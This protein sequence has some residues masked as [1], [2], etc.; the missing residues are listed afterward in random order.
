VPP[1][2]PQL[3]ELAAIGTAV[4]W[5]VTALAFAAAGRRIGSLNVNLIRLAI[6]AVLLA[7]ANL[8]LRGMAFPVDAH[9]ATWRWLLASGLVGFVFG[10]LCLFRA[11]VEIGPRLS[12]LVMCLAPPFAALLGWLGLGERLGWRDLGGMALVLAGIGWAVWER[13]SGPAPVPTP[14]TEPEAGATTGS[15]G[16]HHP[17]LRGLL[18]AVGGALGQAGGLVLAKHGMGPYHPLAATQI[19]VFAGLVGFL[20]V[21]A[22]THRWTHLRRALADRT[23]LAHTG[24]G[25]FFGPFLGVSLSLVAVQHTA[26]GI[27]ASIMSISPVLLVPISALRGEPVGP[28][29][30]LG[31]VL[32]VA[33][34]ALLFLA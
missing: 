11:F 22:L 19:R 25:A 2:L 5:T 12:A 30:W 1:F 8:A 18:L 20:L 21:F 14:P 13:S 7:F 10:D 6:A 26:A 4:C 17:T 31:A 32:A 3:G 29:G 16:G 33:G 15:S 24:L 28:G 34:V 9:A 23:G 27:A